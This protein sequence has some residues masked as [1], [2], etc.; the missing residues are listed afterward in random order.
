[1]N[2]ALSRRRRK[3]IQ[4]VFLEDGSGEYTAIAHQTDPEAE[5]IAKERRERIGSFIARL[6]PREAATVSLFYL[7]GMD[8]SEIGKL[9]GIPPGSVATA[10]HRGRERLHVIIEKESKETGNDL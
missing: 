4:T 1:M 2:V 6:P 9:L 8:Y 3:Q 10:L 7:E 5:L